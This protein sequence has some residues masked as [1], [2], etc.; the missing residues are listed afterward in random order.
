[1]GKVIRLTESGLIN[2]IK[3]ILIESQDNNVTNYI[4]P[5]LDSRCVTIKYYT[6]YIVIDVE[7]PS[8]F[9]EH[10]FNRNEGLRVKAFLKKNGYNSIGVGEYAKKIDKG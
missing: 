9:E 5:Y 3:K 2:L 7:S 10:G 1:M 6:Q 8:Y 4:Q